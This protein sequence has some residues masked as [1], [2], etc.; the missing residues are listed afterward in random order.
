MRLS[1]LTP[2]EQQFAA[3]HIR[4]IDKF[5]DKQ[6]LNP[7]DW[8]DIAVF[9]YLLAVEK[10]LR[11]PRLQRYAF[12]TIAWKTMYSRIGIE[13]KKQER[14]IKT[15]SLDAPLFTDDGEFSL[16]DTITAD[17][18][19]LL[20]IGGDQMQIKYNVALPERRGRQNEKS[21]EALAI[22]SFILSKTKNMCFEYDSVEE[23][24]KKLSIVT[25]YKRKNNHQGIYE[26]YRV[27]NCIYIV[28][29]NGGNTK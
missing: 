11:Q 28:R 24:K 5:L 23:A 12:S 17:N 13:L 14:R 1:P 4:L 26:H 2:E 21:D 9:G 25:Y 15:I 22:D 8:Y 3:D 10:W 7:S 20:Y 6:S 19:N 29:V 27:E 18:L 16:M